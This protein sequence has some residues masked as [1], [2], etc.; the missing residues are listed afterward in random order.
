MSKME[1][2]TSLVD[3]AKQTL[4]SINDKLVELAETFKGYDTENE[5]NFD[6][7]KARNI[8]AA[9]ITNSG[10]KI[11][12]ASKIASSIAEA[13]TDFQSKFTFGSYVEQKPVSST[14]SGS[15]F[16]SSGS[17][18][19]SSYSSYSGSSSSGGYYT[20]DYSNTGANE[21]SGSSLFEEAG[22]GT[23][24][25]G[26]AMN[27]IADKR[28]EKVYKYTDAKIVPSI[29]YIYNYDDEESTKDKT[30][31]NFTYD[32][33]T[34][35][36]VIDNMFVIKC[37]DRYGKPG[38]IV[39]IEDEN[40]VKYECIIGETNKTDYLHESNEIKIEF[41]T[42]LDKKAEDSTEILTG[43]DDG[44]TSLDE[45]KIVKISNYGKFDD[46]K[47]EKK[48]VIKNPIDTSTFTDTGQS[49]TIQNDSDNVND[50]VSSTDSSNLSNDKNIDNQNDN[51][52]DKSEVSETI[53]TSGI[54]IKQNEDNHVDH[55]EVV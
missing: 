24:I 5:K 42:N 31:L 28:A 40:G 41:Y 36:A 51:N 44:F 1:I 25:A 12:N 4:A 52:I 47:L 7:Y 19:Y 8:I 10:E 29:S 26:L 13:H 49:T 2:D 55:F 3:E 39:V 14:T 33:K 11:L 22:T 6:F 54:T 38:D 50:I 46:F 18:G 48:E 16:S 9:S 23:L 15:G 34:G 53:K 37:D 45:R 35:L 30:V 32:E 20:T 21:G 43:D 27:H 17:S